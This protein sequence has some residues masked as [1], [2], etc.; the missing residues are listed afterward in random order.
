MRT[1]LFYFSLLAVFPLF[2]EPF[3]EQVRIDRGVKE[4]SVEIQSESGPL[5]IA[6]RPG[7]VVDVE[8]PEGTT[9]KVSYKR[10]GDDAKLEIEAA[11]ELT[12]ALPRSAI[13]DI[14]VDQKKGPLSIQLDGLR[15]REVNVDKGGG[16]TTIRSDGSL[17]DLETIDVEQ[18][19]GKVAVALGAATPELT[20][21]EIDAKGAEVALDL[22]GGF[23]RLAHVEV[24][25]GSGN[26]NAQLTG[27]FAK[28]KKVEMEATTG[29]VSID[30]TGMWTGDSTIWVETTDGN[31]EVLIPKG[32]GVIVYASSGSGA[33]DVKGLKQ[34]PKREMKELYKAYRRMVVGTG[35]V[36]AY[37]NRAYGR[38][39]ITLTLDLNTTTGDIRVH[40]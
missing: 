21:V 13:F 17:S 26:V 4:V 8:A 18:T 32:V 5:S 37:V 27:A 24:D 19:G 33:I 2:G 36:V 39:P 3:A 38:D 22:T 15:V 6:A 35:P 10:D 23:I 34:L 11:A 28:L 14:D 7:A 30:L 16:V 25:G 20:S 40:E 12:V 1:A 9:P 31:C 29:D